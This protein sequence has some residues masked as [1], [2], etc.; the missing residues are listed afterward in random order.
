MPP[1]PIKGNI[2]AVG[3]VDWD[4]RLFDAL[5]PLPDGTS[6]N[7]YLIKGSQKTALLDTVDPT[8]ADVLFENLKGVERIDYVIAHHAEQDHSGCLPAVLS[9]APMA[10][11]VCS[12]KAKGMLIDHLHLDASKITAVEDG[13]TLS[14]GDV[15]LEFAHTPWVHWPETMSTFAREPKILFSCD[16]FGSHLAQSDLFVKDEEHVYEAAKRYF[17][18]I[19][20]PF[21]SSIKRNLERIKDFP[22]EMIAPS[23]GPIHS[24][25]AFILDAY[26]DWVGDRP[27]NSA[28]IP[29]VTMHGSTE[30]LVERLVA[31]LAE[32]GVTAWPFNIAEG[33][34]G[35]LAIA[36]V[37]AATI[38]IGSPTVHVGLHPKIAY[39]A[40]LANALRPR[41]KFAAVIGSYGWATKMAEQVLSLT[42]HLKLEVLPGVVVKG[43]PR[44]EDFAA[45][46]RLADLIAAKH[47]D[48]NLR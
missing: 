18:E 22:V 3:A 11:V 4:R 44:S 47:G 2:F 26:R 21:R 6:Y 19:M 36:L 16:F 29:Y 1:C 35:K 25:P 30:L 43:M 17:A 48:L 27:K 42:P 12:T 23:H 8:K 13:A 32:R 34:I 10:Q 33:D 15:T 38:V 20:M 37:D 28:V 9:R 41:A 14:L 5:I 24:R 31:A 39:A 40:F 46:E 7:A 45:V